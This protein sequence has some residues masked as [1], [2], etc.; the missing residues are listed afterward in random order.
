MVH[1]DTCWQQQPLSPQTVL[2]ALGPR[3]RACVSTQLPGTVRTRTVYV[4]TRP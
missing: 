2:P 3:Y 4:S 1:T